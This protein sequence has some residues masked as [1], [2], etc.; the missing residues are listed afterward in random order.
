[1][2][3][4]EPNA[5]AGPAHQEQRVQVRVYGFSSGTALSDVKTGVEN[6]LL[7]L[8]LPHRSY[9]V[10]HRSYQVTPSLTAD[11]MP[12][13]TVI[14]ECPE[15]ASLAQYILDGMQYGEV[16]LQAVWEGAAP[17]LD[18]PQLHQYAQW[19]ATLPG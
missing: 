9:Q 1:M 3:S 12:I 17:G 19:L 2:A 11:N 5:T 7:Y 4:V 6:A 8:S 14:S 13:A 15:I 10:P 18:S 16:Q